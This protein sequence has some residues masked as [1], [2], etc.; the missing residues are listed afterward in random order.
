MAPCAVKTAEKDYRPAK[1]SKDG[2][3]A[4]Q[5]AEQYTKSTPST[6]LC[7]C[8]AFVKNSLI[9]GGLLNEHVQA[10]K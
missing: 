4:P 3:I 2:Y 5:C 8:D 6:A 7:I 9:A 1:L 10:T